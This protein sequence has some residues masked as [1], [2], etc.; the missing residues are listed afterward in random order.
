MITKPEEHEIDRSGKR[1]LRDV[2]EPLEWVV[3]DVQEDYGIDSNVQV[4]DKKSPTGAWFHIQLKSSAS[5]NYAADQSFV[6]QELSIDHARHYALE[7]REPVLL[8]HVDVTAK[9]IFWFAPQLD[10]PLIEGL[11]KTRAKWIT[12]RIPTRQALPGT[13][14][15][16]LATL[17]TIYLALA[18][19]ELSSASNRSFA[20]SI[21][22]FPNQGE[23]HLA[24]QEKSDALKLQKIAELFRHG[25]LEEAR[26]RAESILADLDSAIEIKFWAQIQLEG[27]QFA[28]TV[29]AGKPQ[30]ELSKLILANAKALQ[31]LTASGPKYLKFYAL[32]ARKAAELEL[33]THENLTLF[34][35]LRQHSE[36]GGQPMIALGVYAQKS[37]IT[38]R[39]SLKV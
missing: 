24:F 23:L 21:K 28:Q 1:L 8:I 30:V 39:P 9:K 3:N 18:S 16:L 11:G 38:K 22:H 27:I 17:D 2:L 6:S 25:K 36:R 29:H 33:L 7:M 10:R 20:E 26:P 4:F 12:V 19:R 32:I 31:Q 14:P 13:A 34:M 35:A 5:T 15:V 37:A